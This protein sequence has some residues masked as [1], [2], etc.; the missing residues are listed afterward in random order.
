LIATI[1]PPRWSAKMASRASRAERYTLMP[2][3][4]PIFPRF[5]RPKSAMYRSP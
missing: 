2:L 4:R 1:G 3:R 5:C